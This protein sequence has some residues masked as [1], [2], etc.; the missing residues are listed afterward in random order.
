MRCRQCG[1]P[2][3]DPLTSFTAQQLMLGF[4][5]AL[6]AGTLGG[7]VA[8]QLGF[9]SIIISFFAGGLIAQAVRRVTGYKHGPVMLAIVFGG[10]IT[11]TLVGFGIDYAIEVATWAGLDDELLAASTAGYLTNVAVWAVIAATAACVGAY[12]R[13]R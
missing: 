8:A 9:F 1:R 3:F 12:S 10:I 2:A 6:A 5:V 7:F 13:L 11:G 4:G